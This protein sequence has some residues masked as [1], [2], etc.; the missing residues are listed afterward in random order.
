MKPIFAIALTLSAPMSVLAQTTVFSDDFTTDSSLAA[1]P[2]YN[3]NNTSAASYAL[4]PTAGQ[5]LALTVT[6]GSTGKLN[7]AFAQ[8]SSTPVTLATTGDYLTLTVN[9]NSPSGMAADTGGLLVGLYNTQGTPGTANEQGSGTGGSLGTTGAT[10]NDTGYFGI[11]GYNTSASTST[12]FFGRNP[13]G[14]PV[15]ELAYYSTVGAANYTQL[16]SSAASGNANLLNGT[17]YTLTYTVTKGAGSDAVAAVISQG[18]TTVDSWTETDASGLHN[19]FDELDFGSYGKA[20]PVD[21]NI[22]GVSVVADI[23]AV[24]EPSTLALTGVG[25]LGLVAR[26]RRARQ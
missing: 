22:T 4:N 21:I 24:P 3:L 18:A 25:L 1:P 16:G 7:E 2:W 9:F 14:S 8:F 11:M 12:K 13:G 15:N 26:F 10:A 23:Q 19:S 6:S 20:G 5:G 17:A